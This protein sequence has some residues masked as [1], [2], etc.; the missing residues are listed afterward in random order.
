[1]ADDINFDESQEDARKERIRRQNADYYA[2][3]RDEIN[4]RSKQYYQDNKQDLR[5]KRRVHE[6]KYRE[7][8]AEYVRKRKHDWDVENAERCAEYAAARYRQC[9]EMTERAK[10]VCPAFMFLTHVR[11]ESVATYSIAY[12]PGERV[13]PKMVKL[14]DALRVMDS[15]ICPLVRRGTQDPAEMAAQCPMRGAFLISGAACEIAKIAKILRQN[16]K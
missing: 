8:H 6:K 2:R 11:A 13:V 4:Q 14:C 5:P 16:Q 1:M 7:K 10:F 3:H 15:R 12:K 9:R